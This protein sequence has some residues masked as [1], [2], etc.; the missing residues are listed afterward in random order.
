MRTVTQESRV[1]SPSMTRRKGSE[2][3]FP[4]SGQRTLLSQGYPLSEYEDGVEIEVWL[5]NSGKCL[6][7]LY[8]RG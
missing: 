2:M 8:S 5:R 4:L 6:A 7:P 1:L 3:S